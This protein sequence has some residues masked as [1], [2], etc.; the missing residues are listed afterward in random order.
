[1]SQGREMNIKPVFIMGC[2]RSGTT[3]LASQMAVA[4]NAVAFPEMQFILNLASPT[5]R[6]V[7]K[8]RDAYQQMIGN[9]RY[10]VTG[11][12]IS[13]SQFIEAYQDADL[14]EVIRCL[15]ELNAHKQPKD[16]LIWIEHNPKNRDAVVNLAKAFPEAK[17]IHIVRDPRAIYWSMKSNPRW[18]IGDPLSFSTLWKDAV[19]CCFLHSKNLSERF[20]EVKYED[21]VENSA[22]H[23]QQLCAFVDLKYTDEM[24]NGGG[25]RLPKFTQQQHAFTTKPAEKSRIHQWQGKVSDYDRAIIEFECFDWMQHYGYIQGER[26]TLSL[27]WQDKL[28]C[29]VRSGMAVVQAKIVSKYQNTSR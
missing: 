22:F 27:N 3:M 23:L 9:F 21:Y 4:E 1:M 17:F 2:Q 18:H 13:E 24:L 25:V 12:S 11:L 14:A 16:K 5:Y 28:R 6:R 15:V 20:V 29:S 8:A 19:A 10:Q 26:P 7:T